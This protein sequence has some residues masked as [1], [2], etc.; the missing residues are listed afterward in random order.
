MDFTLKILHAHLATMEGNDLS[1]SPSQELGLEIP[2]Q[3]HKTPELAS[4]S[5]PQTKSAPISASSPSR[6]SIL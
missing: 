5:P 6:E 2:I 1:K 4:V 3:S